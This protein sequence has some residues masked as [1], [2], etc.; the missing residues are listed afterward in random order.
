MCKRIQFNN[1]VYCKYI[2]SVNIYFSI[3]FNVGG[4]LVLKSSKSVAWF[5]GDE[6]Q[7]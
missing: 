7:I 3:Y 5:S 2:C 6:F 4:D 1:N